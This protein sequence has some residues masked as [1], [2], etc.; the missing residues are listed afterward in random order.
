MLR[1]TYVL[2]FILV[3]LFIGFIFGAMFYLSYKPDLTSYLEDFK[4]VLRVSKQNTFVTDLGLLSLIF[5]LSLSIIGLPLSFFYIF[6]EGFSFGFTL[7]AFWSTYGLSGLLFYL[8]FFVIAKALFLLLII[9][10]TV[11]ATRFVFTFVRHSFTDKSDIARQLKNHFYRYLLVAIFTLANSLFIYFLA[12]D[13][14][15]L[16]IKLLS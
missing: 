7:L 12:N 10:F 1:K 6:Y 13:I 8:L 4:E 3:L 15:L 11:M 5:V 14:L 9:Y 2:K 16:A